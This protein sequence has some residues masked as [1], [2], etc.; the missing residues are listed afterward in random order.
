MDRD[1]EQLIARNPQ[2]A[3]ETIKEMILQDKDLTM[4]ELDEE[5]RK[6]GVDPDESVKRLFLLAQEIVFEAGPGGRVSPHVSDVLGQLSRKCLGSEPKAAAARATG[7]NNAS[8][9]QSG[10]AAS[11]KPKALAAVL[12][13]H[14]NY[15]EES[16]KDRAIRL[17]NEKRLQEQAERVRQKKRVSKK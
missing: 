8:S 9:L 2:R 7:S 10:R 13:Y 4:E 12:S 5:L 3:W 6:Y 17:K 16:A 14:R 11:K 1:K 15:K